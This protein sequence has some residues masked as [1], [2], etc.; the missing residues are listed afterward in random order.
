MRATG[1]S[2][3]VA[4]SRVGSNIT[5]NVNGIWLTGNAMRF[6][7]T[8]TS[9]PGG[10]MNANIGP[11]GVVD[12]GTR[13]A[14][15]NM[16]FYNAVS[17][18]YFY[19]ISG[20]GILKNKV[21]TAGEILYQIGTNGS[22]SPVK[23]TNTGTEGLIS[24]GVKNTIDYPVANPNAVVRKQ[25][26]ITPANPTGVNLAISLGWL[27][28][29]QAPGFNPANGLLIGHYGGTSWD[30][31]N[32]TLSGSGT[33]TSPY[34]AKASGVTSFSPFIVSNQGGIILPLDLLSF[35]G[36]YTGKKVDLLWSTAHE[37]NIKNFAVEI[38]NNSVAFTTIGMVD[39]KGG[40]GKADYAFSDLNPLNGISYYRLRIV[41]KD[42]SMRYSKVITV[43]TDKRQPISVY[44]NPAIN[45]I[46]VMHQMI[47]KPTTL[48]L[49]TLDGKIMQ[50]ITL[51]TG[52]MQTKLD[53]SALSKGYY[54]VSLNDDSV[55]TV[56]FSK[57]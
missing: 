39:A 18:Q 50:T 10:T 56:V 30:E 55:S 54:L 6:A 48:K 13:G 53:V 4:N 12:A 20:N 21:G 51:A 24:V 57:Q 15:T 41:E 3:I 26:N 17:G 22:Y 31:T 45:N 11:N 44:P 34:Y 35:T 7:S 19:N 42:G 33:V 52:T 29:D 16:V 36:N 43:R 47:A 46:T 28:A 1:T 49:Y 37:E 2:C 38:S 27:V 23:L 5:I 8:A 32:A 9:A 40:I 14:P 25:Y